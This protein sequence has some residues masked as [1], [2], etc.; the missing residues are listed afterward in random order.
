MKKIVFVSGLVLI[1]ACVYFCKYY[2]KN[3]LCGRE[4]RG[5]YNS[6]QYMNLSFESNTE[7]VA[8]ICS[9]DFVGRFSDNVYGHYHYKKP[10][11][12]ISWEKVAPDNDEY[13]K[14]IRCPDSVRVDESLE[15][16]S[17]YDGNVCYVMSDNSF[18][19]VLKNTPLQELPYLLLLC[20]LRFVFGNFVYILLFCIVLY[21]VV[22]FY[23]KRKRAK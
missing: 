8:N 23:R 22:R 7:V 1:A 9:A 20:F 19:G 21:L 4:F 17:Y 14:V 15:S 11:V 10:Y 12:V 3:E 5:Y 6:C 16:L 2:N 13:K 18:C